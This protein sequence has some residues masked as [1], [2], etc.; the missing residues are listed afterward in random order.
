VGGSLAPNLHGDGRHRND[1]GAF[2]G[3]HGLMSASN[4][5][6]RLRFFAEALGNQGFVSALVDPTAEMPD[7]VLLVA[8]E[9]EALAA[10]RWQLEL[11]FIPGMEE[12]LE[13]LSLLQCFVGFPHELPE[14]AVAA[15]VRAATVLNR[16][17][18]LVGF[19]VLDQPRI[20]CYRHTL[21]LPSEA[22]AASPLVVQTTWLIDYLLKMF[23][24]TMLA[25][26]SGQATLTEALRDHP[27]RHLF[28]DA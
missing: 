18:P 4:P 6:G 20:A 22:A 7:A 2:T 25:V 23:G 19:G 14:T 11:S 16:K 15:T 27:F 24:Q 5:A 10:R 12:Q 3:A 21:L 26:A 8:L 17:L 1:S 13:G 28:P 9:D